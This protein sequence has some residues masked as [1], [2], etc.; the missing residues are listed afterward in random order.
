[1]TVSSWQAQCRPLPVLRIPEETVT[2]APGGHIIDQ[3]VT[4]TRGG[5]VPTALLLT[6]LLF[7]VPDVAF[8]D[9][10]VPSIP[11]TPAARALSS[12]LDAFNSGDRA[13]ID[14]YDK[15]HF[16]ALDTSRAMSFRRDTGGFELLGVERSSVARIIF[17]VRR[18]TSPEE[19]VGVLILSDSNPSVIATLRFFPM[20]PGAKYEE[21]TLDAAARSRIIDSV[22]RLL[23]ES[24]VFPDV[25]KK[26]ATTLRTKQTRGE[27][28]DIVDGAVF[29]VRL[30]DDLR[31]VSHDPHLELRFSPVAQQP[32]KPA[33]DAK[34]DPILS[35]ELVAVNCGFEKAE[36]LAP[37]IGYLKVNEFAPPE[38]CAA[39][40]AAAMNFV[41]DSDA[42][43]IDLRDNHGGGG[44]GQ[45]IASYLFAERTHLNDVYSRQ[46]NA[47][48][49]AWTL[50]Y[51]PGKKLI[52][53]PIFVLTSKQT[54]SAAEDFC[55]ALKNLKRA[56]LIG[57]TTGGGAHPGGP[58]RID[59]HFSI[60]VPTG[61]SISPI[62]KTDWEGTGVEPDVKVTADEALTEALRRARNE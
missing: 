19:E 41:A 36:H 4:C 26:M 45:F 3:C 2:L 30:S 46:D 58:H 47:T 24:Y 27:Y 5:I 10:P 43:I 15:E 37:N 22:V 49:E 20:P 32:E 62:T 57:E 53:K 28:K 54:F 12:W 61:R 1:M 29:A 21:V 33:N 23:E 60:W 44:M 38:I 6:A 51:V 11:D 9:A 56:T 50:P 42:L 14:S 7:T 25:A 17:H 34:P 8:A 52:G 48:H 18:K 40:A 59:D 13:R 16:P 31:E 55:Y 35:R 39:T